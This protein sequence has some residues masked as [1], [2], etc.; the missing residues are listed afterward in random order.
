[1]N[2]ANNQNMQE[3]Y[4]IILKHLIEKKNLL[5]DKNRIDEAS[6]VR[7][8]IKAIVEHP[9]SIDANKINIE[10]LDYINI[11]KKIASKTFKDTVMKDMVG[12]FYVSRE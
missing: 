8:R 9:E 1:M 7:E 12:L 6:K 3:R 2:I 10:S 5:M 11:L 4:D